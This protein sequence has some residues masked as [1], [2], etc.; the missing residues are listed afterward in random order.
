MKTLNYR[1]AALLAV[2][3]LVAVACG[4]DSSDTTEPTVD[5]TDTT[6]NEPGNEAPNDLAGTRWVATDV[7]VGGAPLQIFPQ[8][9]PTIDFTDDGLSYGGTTGCNSY[10]GDYTAGNG[11]ITLGS[12]G[13]TEMACEEPLMRQ[14]SEV[15]AILQAATTYSLADGVL[16]IGQL[17]G[18]AIQFIDRTEAFPDA[19][20]TGTQWIADSIVLGDVITSMDAANPVTLFIDAAASE[21][22]G[23]TGCNDYTASV[24]ASRTQ[25]TFGQ[26]SVT[27]RGCVG[28]GIMETEAFVLELFQGEL[29]VEISGSRLTL[30][31][32]DGSGLSFTVLP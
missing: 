32:A 13:Q 6:V 25:L 9:E 2:L 10:F 7:F 23:S 19:E 8:A 4:S 18:S 21:A 28:E 24:E 20:L 27:E 14:E 31:A 15:L 3:A 5:P 17:G 16:T 11:T 22:T 1:F 29:S 30:L 26:M 12:I